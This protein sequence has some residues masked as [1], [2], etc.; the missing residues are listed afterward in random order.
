MKLPIVPVSAQV[1]ASDRNSKSRAPANGN[2]IL[3]SSEP[4]EEKA[5]DLANVH[6]INEPNLLSAIQIRKVFADRV[7]N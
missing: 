4:V 2:L 5:T 6:Q 7:I 3:P 1:V